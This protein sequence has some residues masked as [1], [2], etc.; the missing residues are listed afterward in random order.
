MRAG[1]PTLIG[2][3]LIA[4]AGCHGGSGGDSFSTTVPGSSQVQSL[5][6]AQANQ[7]CSDLTNYLN[8]QVDSQSFCQAAAVA[9]TAKAA[10]QDPTLTDAQLQQ[11]CEKAT[12]TVCPTASDGGFFGAGDGGASACGSTTGCSATVE[13]IST[14]ATGTGASLAQFEKMFPNCSMVTRAK[15]STLNPDASPIEPASCVP[16]DTSCPTWGPMAMMGAG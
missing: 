7:L 11:G 2:F 14:C 15:L 3:V 4:V 6:P 9:G 5:T 13:Q 10:A 1:F 16:I 12:T 8:Q